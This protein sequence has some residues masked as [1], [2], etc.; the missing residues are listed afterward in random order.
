MWSNEN[1][2]PAPDRFRDVEPVV[3][4]QDQEMTVIWGDTKLNPA[5]KERVWKAVIFHR[6]PQAISAVALDADSSSA[7][8]MLYTVDLARGFLYLSTHKN[9]ETLGLSHAS[10]YVSKCS[11]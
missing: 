10:T 6:S 4:I 7:A 2:K 9:S 11:G 5:G 8:S 3:I 1:H